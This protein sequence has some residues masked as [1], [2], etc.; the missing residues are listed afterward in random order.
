MKKIKLKTFAKTLDR[1]NDKC[2]TECKFHIRSSKTLNMITTTG[3]L[4]SLSKDLLKMKIN[5]F[6]ICYSG[7]MIHMCIYVYE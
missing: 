5:S 1:Y 4:L 7:D 2:E 3:D 6:S